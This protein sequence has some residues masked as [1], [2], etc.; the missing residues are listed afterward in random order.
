MKK[1]KII[2]TIFCPLETTKLK[3]GEVFIYGDIEPG[4]T[5]MY[6]VQI[7]YIKSIALFFNPMDALEYAKSIN[8]GRITV[9]DP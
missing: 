1:P 6:S 3:K 2:K 9:N 7:A 5:D 4:A 8:D